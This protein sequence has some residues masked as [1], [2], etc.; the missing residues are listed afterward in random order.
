MDVN[1]LPQLVFAFTI[2]FARIGTAVMLLP[3]FGEAYVPGRVRLVFALTLTTAI[4]P[5]IQN[6]LPAVPEG[7][8][9]FLT[10]IIT[11]VAIGGF[12]GLLAKM[13]FASLMTA[14]VVIA[15][16]TSLS[17]ALLF[18][19]TQSSQSGAIGAFLTTTGLVILFATNMHHL[20][21]S[22]LVESY[23]VFKIVTKDF[24]GDMA[25][26][27]IKTLSG[28][29]YLAVKMAS[30]FI[31]MSLVLNSSMGLIAKLMPQMQVYFVLLPVQ[32]SLG[33]LIL[34]LILPMVMQGF[35]TMY[36]EIYSG[37]LAK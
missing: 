34:G 15:F 17:N 1:D 2:C 22:A 30:P 37:F 5:I 18:D 19:P 16:H 25:N 13:V 6:K 7:S 26:L 28:S 4:F 32:I 11:E 8:F 31:F 21:I 29:F 33:L 27:V 20:V 35:V 9:E 3:G 12:L 10:I 36:Y 14:G 24:V 23:D